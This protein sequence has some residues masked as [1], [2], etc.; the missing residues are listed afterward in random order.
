MIK[1]IVVQVLIINVC[2]KRSKMLDNIIK[3]LSLNGLVSKEM[4]EIELKL[5]DEIVK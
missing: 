2:A 1:I 3:N 4:P 5:Y